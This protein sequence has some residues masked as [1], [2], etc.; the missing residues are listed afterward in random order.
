MVANCF[1]IITF[2]MFTNISNCKCS[3]TN[4]DKDDKLFS[5]FPIGELFYRKLRIPYMS[6]R[7][8]SDMCKIEMC[9]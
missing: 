1:I 9:V 6:Y 8:I 2:N 4:I 3:S 7:A 5:F